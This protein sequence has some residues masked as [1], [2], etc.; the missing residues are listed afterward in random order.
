MH[1]PL[2]SKFAL[3]DQRDATVNRWD[4]YALADSHCVCLTRPD[5]YARLTVHVASCV[6]A[7]VAQSWLQASRHF[8]LKTGTFDQAQVPGARLAL[9]RLGS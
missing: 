7:K 2:Y 3:I 8:Q 4:M 5:S 9:N 6:C 1:E